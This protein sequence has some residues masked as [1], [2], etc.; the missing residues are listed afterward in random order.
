MTCM[1]LK[2][3][4]LIVITLSVSTDHRIEIKNSI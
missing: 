3:S 4:I 2:E 1:K